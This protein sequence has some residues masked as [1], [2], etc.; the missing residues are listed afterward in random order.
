MRVALLLAVFTGICA[1]CAGDQKM[2]IAQHASRAQAAIQANNADLA[3]AELEALLRIDPANVNA[4]ASLG[5]VQYTKGD[6]AAAARQFKAALSRSPGLTSARAFLGMCEVRSG[7]I[8]RGRKLLEDSFPQITDKALRTQAGLELIRSYAAMDT[9]ANAEPVIRALLQL[10][11]K[12]PEVLYTAYRVHSELASGALHDLT[13]V[14]GDSLWVHE[15]LAQ[16]LMVQE[17]YSA[18]IKEY[19][20]AL[21]LSSNKLGLHYQLGEALFAEARTEANRTEAEKE[22]LAEL[23]LNPVDAESICKLGEIALERSN[24]G[25][26]KQLYLRALELRPR[27][28]GAH[29]ALGKI[30]ADEGNARAAIEHLETAALIQ[31]D[32][33]TTHYR[34]AKLYRD[35]GRTAEADRELATF[36]KLSEAESG[37]RGNSAPGER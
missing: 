3:I 37:L 20:K 16:N 15:I 1:L 19:R 9:V 18:A 22:F 4:I 32:V 27:L 30:L 36:R 14:A 35:E 11:P 8:Q 17:Q 31:P 23:E 6:Y 2:E 13:K 5:M 29:A 26:A 34:L 25:K 24:T 7:N 10:D 12:N 28:A 21:G 33:K